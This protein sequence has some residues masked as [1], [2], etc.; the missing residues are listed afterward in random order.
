MTFEVG[1]ALGI[2]GLAVI[3]FLSERVRPDVVALIVL[4]LVAVTGLVSS[5]APRWHWARYSGF[6]SGLPQ[7]SCWLTPHLLSCWCWRG[8]FADFAAS[9]IFSWCT[10]YIRRSLSCW[11]FWG[12]GPSLHASGEWRTGESTA[13]LKR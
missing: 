2:L 5:M 12:R 9:P 11:K 6:P 3:L 7:T 13:A 8:Y 10:T 1:L 4:V